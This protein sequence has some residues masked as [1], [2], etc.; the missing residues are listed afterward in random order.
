MTDPIPDFGLSEVWQRSP[1]LGQT[2]YHRRVFCARWKLGTVSVYQH[3]RWLIERLWTDPAVYE[4]NPWSDIRLKSTCNNTFVTWWGPGGCG[5]TYDAAAQAVE[6]WLED[7][8]HTAVMVC[9]TTKEMLRK[10]I[11]NEICTLWTRLPSWIAYKGNLLNTECII[12]WEEGNKKNGIFGFAVADGPV[13]DAINNL[14]GIHTTRVWLIL[15]EMQG[16]EDAIMGVRANHAKNPEPRFLGMGNPTNYNSMLCKYSEP[17]GG[18]GEVGVAQTD[19]WPIKAAPYIG[20]GKCYFFDG[21]KSPA[22]LDPAWGA[23]HPYMTNQAQLDGIAADKGENSPDYWTDGIGWPPPLGTD[24]TVLDVAVI[25]KFQCKSKAHWTDGYEEGAGLDPAFTEGGD[26]KVLQFVRW[27]YV[28]DEGGKRWVVE[29]GESIDIHI[30]AESKDPVE[31]Q[32]LNFCKEKCKAKGIGHHNFAL[33][34]TGSG[35][36]L[37]SLFTQE[38]GTCM[39]VDFSGAPSDMVVDEKGT[40]ASERFDRKSS[41]LNIMVRDF[42]YANGLRGL[43]QKAADDFCQR[44][45][46]KKGKKDS[47]E[48]KKEMK[49]RL[50]RS[51]DHADAVTVALFLARENGAV[52]GRRGEAVK[53]EE[54]NRVV[55][56]EFQ[57][58]Y[59]SDDNVGNEPDPNYMEM[60]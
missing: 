49:K 34:S 2:E 20:R 48:S 45:T 41:E 30:N 7:P 53:N 57:R 19:S 35:H 37:H 54:S 43:G 12:Q 23:A 44:L 39:A 1:E 55:D 58:Q 56:E 32:I 27:G 47:V 5:K 50:K 18:W 46:L 11:W 22:I 4:L 10:R 38:W 8:E 25:D 52:P 3:R 29:L 6:F 33:D 28:N 13:D 42:A 60:V 15:D 16:I 21:R 14:R 9:S 40:T 59:F 26:K 36:T 31:Y 17:I 24:I 51:P